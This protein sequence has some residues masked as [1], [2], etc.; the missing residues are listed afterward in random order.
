MISDLLSPEKILPAKT[1]RPFYS[2]AVFY[3]IGNEISYRI[4]KDAPL[5]MRTLFLE[6]PL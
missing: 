4:K 5:R 1:A 2:L 6:S 3:M